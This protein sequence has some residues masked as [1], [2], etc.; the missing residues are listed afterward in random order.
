VKYGF[1]ERQRS[2][3]PVRSMCRLLKVSH[4]GFYTW[5]GRAASHR[6]LANERL[7]GLIR[8]SF[9]QSD[10]TYGSPRVWRDLLA[11][12]EAVG[13]NRVARLM[14]R[15]QLQARPKR[16][17]LPCDHGMRWAHCIATNVLARQFAAPA[18]NRTWA[19]DFTICGP[20]KA[21][22]MWLW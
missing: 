2:V 21:G 18:A 20:P 16:R 11:W 14:H 9:A 12:G 8:Q 7:L 22:C 1:I 19:A 6:A 4:G 13:E 10:R 15:A 3:W 5:A 17:R